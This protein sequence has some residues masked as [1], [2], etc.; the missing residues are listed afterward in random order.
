VVV[1]EAEVVEA[2]HGGGDPHDAGDQGEEHEEAGG[3]IADGEENGMEMRWQPQLGADDEAAFDGEVER[4]PAD[5]GQDGVQAQVE[6]QQQ[7]GHGLD[8][9]GHG[10]LNRSIDLC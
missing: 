5:D 2:H 7:Q 4:P 8:V 9:L 1:P 3:E 6:Q 10:C